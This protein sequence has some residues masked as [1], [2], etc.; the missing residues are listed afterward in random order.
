MY[1]NL[2]IHRRDTEV[3]E[4]TQRKTEITTPTNSRTA[5]IVIIILLGNWGNRAEQSVLLVIDAG[6]E[7]KGVHWSRVRSISKAERPK[8]LDFKRLTM[9]AAKQTMEVSIIRIE[10]GDLTAAELSDQ[11]LST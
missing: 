1:L 9:T 10:T 6:S 11:Q 4:T 5:V 7:E 3:G 8:S 2:S